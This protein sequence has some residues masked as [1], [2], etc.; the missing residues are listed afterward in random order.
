M[1]S[2]EA[3]AVAREAGEDVLARL[4]ETAQE[5]SVRGFRLTSMDELQN[6]VRRR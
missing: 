5:I 6:S 2:S 4:L 3:A 1:K